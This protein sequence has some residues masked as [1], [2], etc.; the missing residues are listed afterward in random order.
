[1]TPAPG[2][3][4]FVLAGGASSRFG[5]DKAR[6]RYRGRTLVDRALTTL[7]EVAGPVRVVAREPWR[8]P[9]DG[10]AGVHGMVVGERPGMGPVEGLRVA[11]RACPSDWALVAGVD[12]PGLSAAAL[13]SL[14]DG[15]ADDV[16]VVCFAE[17]S[18]RRHPVPGCYRRSLVESG[19]LDAG[20]SLQAVLDSARVRVFA[21]P[22]PLTVANVNRPA[23]FL[24]FWDEPPT[25]NWVCSETASPS[26]RVE[27]LAR[28][29]ATWAAAEA[30]L[31]ARN[32]VTVAV[33]AEDYLAAEFRIPVFGWVDDLELHRREDGIAV[34]SASRVGSWDLGVNRRR[35]EALR[36]G[37]RARLA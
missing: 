26:H 29:E 8:V 35:V 36:R 1:V 33:H 11:L 19:R 24:Q 10:P 25:S 4:G 14:L 18:G 21:P 23:D 7:E 17:A 20:G 37:L 13:R 3:S 9:A 30:W 5:S 2:V 22:D 16:D 15:R 27:Q 34:R 31:R 32:D 12:M 6:A 28:T